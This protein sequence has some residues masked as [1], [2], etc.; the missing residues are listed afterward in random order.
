MPVELIEPLDQGVS[1]SRQYFSLAGMLQDADHRDP[2]GAGSCAVHLTVVIPAA[3][4]YLV[5]DDPLPAGLEA[6]DFTIETD[7]AVPY[8]LYFE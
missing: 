5:V 7:T 1:L 8:L 2:E 6:V 4:H 3:V